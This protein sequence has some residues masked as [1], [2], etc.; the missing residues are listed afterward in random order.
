M[1][2]SLFWK[3]FYNVFLT[4]TYIALSNSFQINS[5]TFKISFPLLRYIS[6]YKYVL[7]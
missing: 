5:F 1:Y 2:V 3:M 4:L 7:I 6:N